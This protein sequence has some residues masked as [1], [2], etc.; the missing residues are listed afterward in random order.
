MKKI[1]LEIKGF[2]Y[3]HSNNNAYIL[4]LREAEGDRKL[5]IV[6]GAPEAQAIAFTLEK[7]LKTSRPMTHDVF[8]NTLDRFQVDLKEIIIHKLEDGLFYSS[9]ICERDGIQEIIDSRTSDAIAMA[10]RFKAPIYT[11]P[12]ILE[13]AGIYY[14]FEEKSEDQSDEPEIDLEQLKITKPRLCL[15]TNL[16]TEENN[17]FHRYSERFIRN[18]FSYFGHLCPIE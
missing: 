17:E 8:K 15:E 4:V 2:T 10:Q 9:L 5:P 7:K 13:Q 14:T 12:E 16:K 6:I 1:R 3:G 11:Y 18:C